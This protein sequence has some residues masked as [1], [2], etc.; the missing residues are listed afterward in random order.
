MSKVNRHGVNYQPFDA[1]EGFREAISDANF[2]YEKSKRPTLSEDQVN[3][4]NY[5]LIDAIQNESSITVKYY[6]NGYFY[7]HE[8]IVSKI[9]NEHIVFENNKIILKKNVI[10]II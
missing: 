1:L 2:E 7:L 5:K 3:E 10:E 8:G 6:K 4:I 9:D